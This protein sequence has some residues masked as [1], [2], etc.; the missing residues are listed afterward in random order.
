MVLERT[1]KLKIQ[2]RQLDKRQCNLL[3]HPTTTSV[4]NTQLLTNTFTFPM[5]TAA[6]NGAMVLRVVDFLMR[7]LDAAQK[8]L[9]E[10]KQ[11]KVA[12]HT[13]VS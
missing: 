1:K 4:S 9:E 2:P 6:V 10:L 11:A 12:N 8:K 5:N 3:V 7:E 13:S